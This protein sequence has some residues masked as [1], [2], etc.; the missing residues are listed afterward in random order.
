M[1]EREKWRD[2]M[3]KGAIRSRGDGQRK[4]GGGRKSGK[5]LGG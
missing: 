2:R 5:N 3:E 4:E 1:K